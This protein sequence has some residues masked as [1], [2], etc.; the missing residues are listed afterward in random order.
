MDPGEMINVPVDTVKLGKSFFFGW[1]ASPGHQ[2][3]FAI[4]LK[5]LK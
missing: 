2:V 4:K 3:C 1:K 5:T